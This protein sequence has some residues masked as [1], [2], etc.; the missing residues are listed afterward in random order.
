M[1]DLF[2]VAGLGVLLE[3]NVRDLDE[4]HAEKRVREVAQGEG[5]VRDFDLMAAV[6][7][8]VQADPES[9]SAGAGKEGA[10]REIGYGLSGRGR[11]F[12]D[13]HSSF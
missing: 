8:G 4:A 11:E 3:V 2:E 5:T 9:R 13:G 7:A 10:P 6:R 12:G 1:D